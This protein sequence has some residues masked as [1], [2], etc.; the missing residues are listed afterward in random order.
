MPAVEIL[1]SNI[2]GNVVHVTHLH[3]WLKESGSDGDFKL[4]YRSSRDGLCDGIFHSKCD[5]Q[6]CTITI[7]ETANGFI[8][9]GYSNVSWTCC[10]HWIKA[11]KAFLFAL[12]G[13]DISSPYQISG[14]M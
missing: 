13:S 11:G 2:V 4:L 9:G 1:D 10:N 6:G 8:I 5:H 12:S 3:D 14:R 7:I